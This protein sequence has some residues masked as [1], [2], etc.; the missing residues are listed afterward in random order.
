MTLVPRER[1]QDSPGAGSS[2]GPLRLTRG[3]CASLPPDLVEDPKV[4][5]TVPST[6]KYYVIM[7]MHTRAMSTQERVPITALP[8]LALQPGK[9]RGQCLS[10]KLPRANLDHQD[11]HDQ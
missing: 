5:H 9:P 6:Y 7:Y 10:I 11:L 3:P 8:D 4:A 2:S 1:T